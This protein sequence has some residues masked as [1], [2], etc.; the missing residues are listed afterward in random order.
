MCKRRRR[1]EVIRF[2]DLESATA[3]LRILVAKECESIGIY[4]YLTINK[5]IRDGQTLYRIKDNFTFDDVGN[6]IYTEDDRY[7]V[8]R[9]Y[10]E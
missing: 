10:N 2:K 9:L 6:R 3:A 1:R 8:Y 5:L 7:I 4:D